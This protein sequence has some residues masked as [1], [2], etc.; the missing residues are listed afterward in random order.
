M[1]PL[2][3]GHYAI[4]AGHDHSVPIL[5]TTGCKGLCRET[6][7]LLG[8]QV[9]SVAVKESRKDGTIDLYSPEVTGRTIAAGA[10]RAVT[11]RTRCR[12]FLTE[13]PLHIRLQLKDKSV[14][15]GYMKWRTD[16]KPDW[17]G[18]R[19]GDRVLEATLQTTK[20]IIF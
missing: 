20:H 14:T 1:H 3:D 10:K 7:E 5:M 11:E 9:V 6:R 13:F 4:V 16:S 2:G 17:P 15:D 19:T 8:P 12:P 18:H